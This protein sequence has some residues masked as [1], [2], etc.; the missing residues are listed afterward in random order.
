MADLLVWLWAQASQI[1]QMAMHAKQARP[2]AANERAST[3]PTTG[4]ALPSSCSA[5]L[6]LWA[7]DGIGCGIVGVHPKTCDMKPRA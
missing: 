3:L 6:M 2:I 4:S 5:V 7:K 1:H